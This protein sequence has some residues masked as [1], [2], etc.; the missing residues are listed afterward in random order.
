VVNVGT[1]LDT[2]K[3]GSACLTAWKVLLDCHGIELGV[4]KVVG[5]RSPVTA[6]ESHV[7]RQ[8]HMLTPDRGGGG[9]WRYGWIQEWRECVAPEVLDCRMSTHVFAVF[10]VFACECCLLVDARAGCGCCI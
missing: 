7:C 6:P 8:S 5:V 3:V 2:Q 4:W 1:G 10:A 9:A